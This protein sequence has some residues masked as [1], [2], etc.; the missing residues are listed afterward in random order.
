[1]IVVQTALHDGYDR[2]MQ[3]IEPY[4][5]D[6]EPWPET[7]PADVA[8]S[9]KHQRQE[10]AALASR[11]V[12]VDFTLPEDGVTPEL[13]GLEALWSAIE[14]ELPLGLRE[15]LQQQPEL[16][17]ELADVYYRSARPHIVSYSVAAGV[18]GAVPLPFVNVPAVLS[19]QAKMFH[20]IASIY[21]QRLDARVVSELAGAIG[22]G[23]LV[24]LFAR[25][26]L[27]LIPFVGAAAAGLFTA[28]ATYALGCTLCWYFAQIKH[29][30]VPAAARMQAV[31]QAEL[32]AGRRRFQEYLQG[33]QPAAE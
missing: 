13:Y 27:A 30:L 2:G 20:T 6:A 33:K 32:E 29:G 24:R 4:P 3:H 10:F 8:R 17:G 31:F 19:I 14:Q 28:A 25:S 11:F 23:F 5:Y 26:V 9:L 18:A 7:V 16:Q 21:Q 1:V 12:A 22:T 15:M